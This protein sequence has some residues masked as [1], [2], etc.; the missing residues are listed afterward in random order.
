MMC[1]KVR[2]KDKTGAII[3]SKKMKNTQ[4]NVFYCNECKG[5]HLGNS[6]GKLR[7]MDRINQLL[8]RVL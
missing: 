4:I 3:A 6:R 1:T 2:H 7:K 8:D 5:W